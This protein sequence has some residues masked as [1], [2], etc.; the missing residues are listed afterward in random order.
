MFLFWK[1]D[2]SSFFLKTFPL[3]DA[4][5]AHTNEGVVI[6]FSRLKELAVLFHKLTTTVLLCVKLKKKLCFKIKAPCHVCIYRND[7]DDGSVE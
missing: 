7:D 2:E 1:K 6:P 5:E 4:R 3:E